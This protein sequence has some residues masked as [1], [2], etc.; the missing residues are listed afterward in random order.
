VRRAR[1]ALRA[2]LIAALFAVAVAGA[3]AVTSQLGGRSQDDAGQAPPAAA[4]AS[5]RA[6]PSAEAAPADAKP[7][8]TASAS[9]PAPSPASAKPAPAGYRSVSEAEGFSLAVPN[10]FQRSTDDQR[11]FYVS[12]DGAF[13]IG[14]KAKPAAS[15]GPVTVMRLSHASGPATNP[16]Y[17]DGTVVP[18]TH[19]GLPAA[20]WEFTWNG[21]TAAEGARHT[22]DLC[23]EENGRMYDVW[24]S[25]P[26]G[27]LPEARSHFD[28]AL[29][30]FAAGGPAAPGR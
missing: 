23:W 30:S 18:T 21:F 15:E 7:A 17:R 28:A 5:G 8:R 24:V 3:V 6:A 9:A 29:D 25:A 10:G 20:L 4:S 1:P 27:R 12:P 19:N 11:V 13:R 22:F 14:V 16:G 26:V 2:G